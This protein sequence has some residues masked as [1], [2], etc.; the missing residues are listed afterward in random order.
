MVSSESWD[1]VV[2]GGG[3]AAFEA[4]VACRQAGFE[5]VLMLEKA[6]EDQAGGNAR[7]SHTG[8]RF[9]YSGRDEIRAFLPDV[10]SDLI[11]RMV[12]PPYTHDEFIR[13]L[14]NVTG[15]RMDPALA[16]ALAGESNAA[17]HWVR[18]AGV[19]WDL[20]HHVVINGAFHFEPGIVVHPL[21][22]G[23][24]QLRAWKEIAAKTGVAVRYES[25]VV[26]V[27][28]TFRGVGAIRVA[29]P[30]RYY[31]IHP[32]H[33][34]V[35][36]GGFQANRE[37]RARYLGGHADIMKV[38]G[39]RHN[40]GEVLR[41]L[42]DMGARAGGH[43]QGAHATPIDGKAPDF[44][45]PVRGDG[46]GSWTNRYYYMYGITVNSLGQRFF[47]EGE[48]RQSY[49]YAKTGAAVLAQPGGVAYQIYDRKGAAVMKPHAESHLETKYEAD[50]LE[51]LAGLTGISRDAFLHTVAEFNAACDAAVE[52]DPTVMDGKA[53]KGIAPAKSNWA[54]RIDEP[55]FYAYPIT[56]GITFTFGGLAV[57]SHA[58][59]I[60]IQGEP[61]AGLYAVGDVAGIFF[62]NYPSCTGQTRN[63]VFALKA[64]KHAAAQA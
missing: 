21:G 63:A 61:I 33:T 30:G 43:W 24:G 8:F 38:R 10:D 51:D 36:S 22:G 31:E 40:T 39:S 41:M 47:D 27:E 15:G 53:T 28:G 54:I 58:Q 13:D 11:D 7:F 20:A 9:C 37:M 29:A 49:T 44:E 62:H 42:I 12:V 56:G 60:G 1:V 6:P 2:I 26:A 64:A 25:P 18:E 34:I 46:M 5:R 57:N 19:P 45:V 4:A 59:V 14:D 3:S 50:R 55:P 48:S 52:F 35:C 23:L 17:V 16:E 32:R